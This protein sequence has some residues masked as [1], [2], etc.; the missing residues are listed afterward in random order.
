MEKILIFFMKKTIQ[1]FRLDK[2]SCI[3]AIIIENKT[4][5]S[6][7]KNNIIKNL[8]KIKASILKQLNIKNLKQTQI[9]VIYSVK[10]NF[11]LKHMSDV[12]L[13]CGSWQ[14]VEFKNVLPSLI[15]KALETDGKFDVEISYDNDFYKSKIQENGQI[16]I[17]LV[18][19][20][21]Y[22]KVFPQQI[23]DIYFNSADNMFNGNLEY[24]L[25]KLQLKDKFIEDMKID[26]NALKGEI[27]YRTQKMYELHRD[28]MSLK[29]F[30]NL[31]EEMLECV[32]NQN[33]ELEKIYTVPSFSS[34]SGNFGIYTYGLD[35][36]V[37]KER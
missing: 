4:E 31:K 30:L 35:L 34:G 2:G 28:V 17:E 15:L 14:V 36:I 8:K 24:F 7:N 1:V 21:K 13:P 18:K 20:A 29:D 11:I 25:K 32:L 26:I 23:A 10:N 12:F 37:P 3:K 33:K 5:I 22:K 16:T 9:D 27:Q 6:W 19:K